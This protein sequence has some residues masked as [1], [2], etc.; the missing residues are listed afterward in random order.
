MLGF[1][2]PKFGKAAKWIGGLGGSASSAGGVVSGGGVVAASAGAGATEGE[3]AAAEAANIENINKRMSL[4]LAQGS[5]GRSR[6]ERQ[7]AEKLL[8]A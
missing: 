8:P 4:A 3:I 6:A 5:G 7:P 2:G 1:I